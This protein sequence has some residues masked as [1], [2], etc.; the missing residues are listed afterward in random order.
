MRRSPSQPEKKGPVNRG[1]DCP[2]GSWREF[3]CGRA[4]AA[5]KAVSAGSP[6]RPVMRFTPT[7]RRRA[8]P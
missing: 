5:E 4:T 3:R 2:R 6:S 8:S 1:P 7:S